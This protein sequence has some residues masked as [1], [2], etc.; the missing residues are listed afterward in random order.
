M[1]SLE[2]TQSAKIEKGIN[3]K[4]RQIRCPLISVTFD[5]LKENQLN[6]GQGLR[7][8]KSNDRYIRLLRTKIL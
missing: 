7:S 8:E 3:C 6:F 2:Y 4:T 5:S 1:D